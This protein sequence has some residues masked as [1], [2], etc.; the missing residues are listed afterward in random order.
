MKTLLLL[1]C[2]TATATS[3]LWAQGLPSMENK[4]VVLQ[5]LFSDSPEDPIAF[6]ELLQTARDMDVAQHLLLEAQIRFF[7]LS[8]RWEQAAHLAG[9][10]R[11]SAQGY[12]YEASVFFEH[13]AALDAGILA[14]DAVEAYAEGEIEAME[15]RAKEAFWADPAVTIFFL[16][17][18]VTQYKAEL[19]RAELRLPMDLELARTGEGEATTLGKLAEGQKAVLLDFWAT[20]CAPC[21]RLMPELQEKKDKLAPQGVVVAAINTDNPDKAE[22]IRQQRDMDVTWLAEP[23]SRPLSRQLQI[24]SIPRMI[25]VDPEGRVLFNGHPMDQE[26]VRVLARL[27]VDL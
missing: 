13:P 3:A 7:I 17:A 19:A 10:L 16:G 25:L 23:A 24:D 6:D 11:E 1:L 27:D 15:A 4:Q 9:P 8:Q 20:W 18:L 22:Q 26:L 5:R 2:L 21:L 14:L 12:P